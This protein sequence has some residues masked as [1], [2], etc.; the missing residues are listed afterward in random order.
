LNKP[1]FHCLIPPP[2]QWG[3][4]A[5]FFF[6]FLKHP[7]LINFNPTSCLP[8]LINQPPRLFLHELNQV[9]AEFDVPPLT[10]N[11]TPRLLFLWNYFP[12]LTYKKQRFLGSSLSLCGINVE[13]AWYQVFDSAIDVVKVCGITFILK[14]IWPVVVILTPF[15]LDVL[16]Y[17]KICN[18]RNFFSSIARSWVCLL[19]YLCPSNLVLYVSFLKLRNWMIVLY[20]FFF[21]FLLSCCE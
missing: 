9:R 10:W 15:H 13:L 21:F 3:F 20:F 12:L 17:E 18:F 7:T 14:G 11:K 16:R 4:M 5:F 6:I 1:I 8:T 19:Y 2:C